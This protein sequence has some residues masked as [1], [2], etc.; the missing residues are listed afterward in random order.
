MRSASVAAV[1]FE[2]QLRVP[3]Q[4]SSERDHPRRQLLDVSA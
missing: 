1:L 2:G 3:M 4:L